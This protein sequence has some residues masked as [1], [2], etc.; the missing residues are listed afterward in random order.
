MKAFDKAIWGTATVPANAVKVEG[1]E[2]LKTSGIRY[3]FNFLHGDVITF[4]TVDE[5]DIIN[6]PMANG[7]DVYKIKVVINGTTAKYVPLGSF[8]RTPVNWDT[9][10]FRDTYPTNFEINSLENDYDRFM[11]F[12]N[13]TIKVKDQISMD[14]VSFDKDGQRKVNE[15]NENILQKRNTPIFVEVKD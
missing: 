3:G 12:A 4:P 9:I 11:F 5:A 10:E 8:R 7:K 15:N 6:S 1:L 13:K 2:A 14:Y